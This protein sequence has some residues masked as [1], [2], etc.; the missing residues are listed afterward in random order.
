V[1][2][3]TVFNPAELA[4]LE[5]EVLTD[6]AKKV[7]RTAAL[8]APKRTGAGARSIGHELVHEGGG[9]TARVAWDRLHGYM[10]FPEGGTRYIQ[11]QR[12]MRRAA[13]GKTL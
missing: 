13:E 4:D 1:P 11:A 9:W 6:D 3:R 2:D 12:F 7:T 10:R 8:L 5:R